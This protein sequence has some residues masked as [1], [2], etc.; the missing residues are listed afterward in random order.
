LCS[1]GQKLDESTSIEYGIL[2]LCGRAYISCDS[3]YN[4][5]VD[6][7]GAVAVAEGLKANMVLNTLKYATKLCLL[8]V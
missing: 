8:H 3:L 6:D 5:T 1:I 7:A 4:K 2:L